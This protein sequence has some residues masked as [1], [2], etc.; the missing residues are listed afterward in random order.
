MRRKFLFLIL[1]SGFIICVDQMTKIYVHTHFN[2]SESIDVVSGFFNIT[3]VTNRGAAF[4][5][6]AQAPE[7]FHN[8][9]FLSMPPIAILVILGILHGVEED[10]YL[11]ICSLSCI[12]SGAIGNYID[13]LRLGAVVDFL[14]FHLSWGGSIHSWPAFNIAD[15][16]IVGGVMVLLYQIFFPKSRPSIHHISI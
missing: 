10:D 11:Q 8:I 12:F 7:I 1:I 15:M 9:F 5:F 2:L 14:D 4:G 6:L 3:Y 13:R 16:A